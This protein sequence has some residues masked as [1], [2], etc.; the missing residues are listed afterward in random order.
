MTNKIKYIFFPLNFRLLLL[1]FIPLLSC[2]SLKPGGVKSGKRLFETFYVG[3]DG[4][5]YF[6][7]PLEFTADNKEVLKLDVT[8]RQKDISEDSATVNISFYGAENFKTAD[9]LVIKNTT[10][11]LALKNLSH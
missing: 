3:T 11:T 6:I 8:F 4:T 2:F 1:L 5:Q 10:E 9:S 7:K